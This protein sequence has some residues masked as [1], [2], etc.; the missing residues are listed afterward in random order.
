[1]L[2]AGLS[3]GRATEAHILSDLGD[4]LPFLFLFGAERFTREH[5]RAAASLLDDGLLR[6]RSHKRGLQIATTFE[7]SDL[8]LGLLWHA[9][10]TGDSAAFDLADQVARRLRESFQLGAGTRS[11]FIPA[12]RTAIPI[13]DTRDGLF[14]EL[15][16]EHPELPGSRATA[17]GLL[18]ELLSISTFRRM[19]L[20]PALAPSSGGALFSLLPRARRKFA[21]FLFMKHNSNA[22]YGLLAAA[23]T[24]G[25]DAARSAL[26]TWVAAI[27][28]H[29]ITEDGYIIHSARL[30]GESLTSPE[31]RATSNHTAIDLFSDL[32]Y[33]LGSDRC[34]SIARRV[35]DAWLRIQGET[36]LFPNAP[37]LRHDD[38]DVQTDMIVALAKV[39][40]LT[41]EDRYREAAALTL[42]GVLRYHRRDSGYV[43]RVDVGS[44]NVISTFM[45]TKFIALFLKALHLYHDGGKIYGTPEL[46]EVLRDR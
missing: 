1:M 38:L 37:G 18:S 17:S 4:Y 29:V 7:H 25:D 32:A 21:T 14:L 15:F 5:L 45:K 2:A 42:D 41:G 23:R 24:L 22:V 46:L 3:G 34:L 8:L 26:R 39:G 11:F 33:G 9:R 30:A 20:F 6:P 19:G 12:L 43:L 13:L 27:E 10:R 36:G 44:G 16:A 31:I 40:E 35:A 28:R